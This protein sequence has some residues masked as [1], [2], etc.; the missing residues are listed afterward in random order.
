M[1][2]FPTCNLQLSPDPASESLLIE[3]NWRGRSLAVP[4]H[5]LARSTVLESLRTATE[6]SATMPFPLGCLEI[7]SQFVTGL[8][9]IDWLLNAMK[10]AHFLRDQ[11]TT[12]RAAA[13][14]AETIDSVQSWD[15]PAASK[16]L[17][18]LEQLEPDLLVLVFQQT[19]L[20]LHV[21]FAHL[22]CGLHSC[23]LRSRVSE[24]CLVLQRQLRRS[25]LPTLGLHFS[26]LSYVHHLD[27]SHNDLGRAASDL[28]LL[29]CPLQALTFLSLASTAIG[30]AGLTAVSPHLGN[31]RRLRHLSLADAGLTA[32]AA[33]PLLR[34]LPAMAALE[35]LD[36][37]RNAF[38][39]AGH[40]ALAPLLAA[41]PRLRFLDN[42]GARFT[43]RAF[44]PPT[45]L[46]PTLSALEHLS[47]QVHSTAASDVCSVTLP[48]A[49]CTALASLKLHF[50][51]SSDD[52]LALALRPL[53]HLRHLTLSTS[54]QV[55]LSAAPLLAPLTALTL[56]HLSA[57]RLHDRGAFLSTLTDLLDLRLHQAFVE[58]EA[59]P[60]LAPFLPFL[61]CLTA[62]ALE[63]NSALA[64]HFDPLGHALTQL[65]LLSCL[66]F[67]DNHECSES[68]PSALFGQL[69]ALSL[70]EVLDLDN[71]WLPDSVAAALAASLSG[72]PR[73]QH[74]NISTNPLWDEG[75]RALAAVLPSLCRLTYLNLSDTCVA[76][77]EAA[78]LLAA[79]SSLTAIESLDVSNLCDG[80]DNHAGPAA[81][82]ELATALPS[83]RRLRALN[84]ASADFGHGF[85][86][87][88]RALCALTTLTLLSVGDQRLPE[89]AAAALG[90][91]LAALPALA[92]LD[93]ASMEASAGAVF[94]PRPPPFFSALT[95][96]NLSGCDL[97]DLG[98]AQLG[99][100]VACMSSLARLGLA[101]NKLT[102]AG[103]RV[104]AP[105]LT[106]LS[107]LQSVTLTSND[108]SSRVFVQR[109]R[110]PAL[111]SM[112][113]F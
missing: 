93:M 47:L 61:Q 14:V 4:E 77:L 30:D 91:C 64:T 31:L 83:L 13:D 98:V 101:R 76:S 71:S 96:L 33:K 7:Y 60:P 90:P 22:P 44:S 46:P 81:A 54:T 32:A 34:A 53:H 66:R 51:H 8:G 39:I 85:A 103:V 63:S 68:P 17:Q 80:R 79:L 97:G 73:L 111:S 88:A 104:L 50:E 25:I 109:A 26:T 52:V 2:V 15:S 95:E 69:T 70:L 42:V 35:H 1:T 57:F 40:V 100:G 106:R 78:L 94:A 18:K 113:V 74:L 65:S 49:R 28:A 110:D 9:P 72:L 59:E 21:A 38:D 55:A 48:L 19:K 23:A 11:R 75:A 84:V 105:Y 24:G 67:R 29:L 36:V 62:L 27:L 12:S 5:L 10:V 89:D 58:C 3:W 43:A 108:I 6:G 86:P 37:A 45:I 99:P 92:H 87:L 20:P 41:L 16:L 56:L 107:E 82:F 102:D 112:A